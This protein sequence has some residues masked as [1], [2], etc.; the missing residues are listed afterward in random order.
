MDINKVPMVRITWLDAR[1][2]ETGWLPIKEIIEAPL[3]VCQ[4]VGYM[5]VN[6][7]D[8][9]VIMRSWETY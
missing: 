8:K 1:D 4:E 7:D 2:M 6:N 5:V 3:A 9:V